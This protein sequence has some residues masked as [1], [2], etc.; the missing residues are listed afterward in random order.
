[1]ADANEPTQ[2]GTPV[3]GEQ[4]IFANI[5][6]LQRVFRLMAIPPLSGYAPVAITAIGVVV[7]P[8]GEVNHYPVYTQLVGT[9][10]S[11]VAELRNAIAILQRWLRVQRNRRELSGAKTLPRTGQP[12]SREQWT[13]TDMARLREVFQLLNIQPLSGFTPVAITTIGVRVSSI[14]EVD[15]YV[16]YAQVIGTDLSNA[17]DL[18]EASEMRAAIAIL[19]RYLRL[20]RQR[21]G[22]GVGPR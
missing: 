9:Q 5:A 21:P 3:P 10:H 1:V 16:V 22:P 15:R 17:A 11:E 12:P 13:I 6:E 2:I 19:Q 7:S 14:G 20:L 4:G 18:S 8:A